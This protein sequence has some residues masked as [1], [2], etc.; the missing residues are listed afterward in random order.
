[1]REHTA[2]KIEIPPMQT[3][4]SLATYE[5]GRCFGFPVVLEYYNNFDRRESYSRSR[6]PIPDI[7]DI[8]RCLFEYVQT[9]PNA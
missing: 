8:G 7:F 3:C 9:R 5:C 6:A 2:D 1:M 4:G